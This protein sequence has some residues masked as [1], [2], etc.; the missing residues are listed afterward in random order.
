[1]NEGI[2]MEKH[3]SEIKRINGYLKEIITFLDDSGN[4][5]GHSI[6][7]LMVELKPRDITQLFVGSLL[8]STPLCFT[9]E[10]WKISESLSDNNITYFFCLSIFA[11][12]SFIYF[13]FY[14]YRL[15]GHV[16][17]FIKR[18][19]FTY[20]ISLLSTVLVLSLINKFSIGDH[21]SMARVIIIGFPSIFGAMVTDYLK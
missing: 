1:M 6:N 19:F 16:I 10:V 9:E 4:P 3:R 13:N 2:F 21:P 11:V 14:R 18:I 15:K 17:E 7:P 8:V 12:T 20:L 5:I